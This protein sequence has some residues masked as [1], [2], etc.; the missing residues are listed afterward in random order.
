MDELKILLDLVKHQASTVNT[1]WGFYIT[2]SLAVAGW[3]AAAGKE[4]LALL[5]MPSRVVIAV[6]F[7]AFTLINAFSLSASY[8]VLDRI[9]ADAQ[10]LMPTL[11]PHSARTA[12]VLSPMSIITLGDLGFPVSIFVQLVIGFLVCALV[13]F[14]GRETEQP[15]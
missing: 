13:L 8:S 12:A 2:V 7:G 1:L 3:F 6:A 9:F 14:F 15:A 5:R 10:G 4:K 11:M